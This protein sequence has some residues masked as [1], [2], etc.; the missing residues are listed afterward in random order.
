LV[1]RFQPRLRCVDTRFD[2]ADVA[3]GIDELLIECSAIGAD[4]VDLLLEAELF[5]GCHPLLRACRVEFMVM[6]LKRIGTG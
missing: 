2:V 6:L 3:G 5:V 4:C 1:E